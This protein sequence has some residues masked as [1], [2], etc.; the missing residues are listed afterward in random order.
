ML[1]VGVVAAAENFWR[2]KGHRPSVVDSPA[3]WAYHRSMMP[4]NDKFQV[5]LL[6]ASRIQ[7]SFSTKIFRDRFH[8]LSLTQLAITGKYPLGT[9][10]NIAQDDAAHGLIVCSITANGFSTENWS[11]Q[12]EYVDY[13][14]NQNHNHYL[15]RLINTSFLQERLVVL[16]PQ[17][18]IDRVLHSILA[19][20]PLPRPNYHTTFSDRSKCANYSLTDIEKVRS[21]RIK[22][23]SDKL[24]EVIVSPEVWMQ[25]LEHV[26]K[27]VKKIQQRGGRVVFVRFPTSDEHWAIDEKYFPRELYWDRMAEFTSAETIHFA[28]YPSLSHFHLPDTSHLDCKDKPQFTNALLDILE[29]KGL[30][31][32][33]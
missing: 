5:T 14:N 9:L 18:K 16:S 26:E 6:G 11:D 31:K 4:Q 1:T 28:D 33:E 23:V 20:K 17:I 10:L 12:Q 13:F 25:D 8:N 21:D 24:A 27:W 32:A 30:L 19:R 7:V 22:R 3:L 2:G 29:D 15:T